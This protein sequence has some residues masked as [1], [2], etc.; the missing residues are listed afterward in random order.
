MT[1]GKRHALVLTLMLAAAAANARQPDETEVGN[2]AAAVLLGSSPVLAKPALQQYL[3]LVGASV[4]ALSE[5]PQLA[6]RFAVTDDDA[7]NAFAAP[8]GVVLVTRGLFR[9]LESEDELAAVLAHEIGHVVRKHHYNVIVRQRLADE[10]TATLAVGAKGADMDALSKTS[11]VLFARGLD[12]SAEF[13]ADLYALQLATRAGYDPSAL[14]GVL[15]KLGAI[16][17]ADSRAQLLFAT[18]PSA[19]ERLDRLLRHNLDALPAASASAARKARF[20]GARA[21]L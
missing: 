14:L 18:H 11:S 9:L 6:W 19:A 10:A 7:V 17:A 16:K 21:A 15:E 12:K 20:A 3:N 4:A 5:R 1:I 13:D 8:G 2:A